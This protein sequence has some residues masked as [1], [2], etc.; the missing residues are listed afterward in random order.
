MAYATTPTLLSLD[1]W[2]AI[3][4][5]SPL[6][7]NG[8]V[9]HDIFP[10]GAGRCA[11]VWFQYSWQWADQVGREDLARAIASAEEDIA[12]V[13]GWWPAPRWFE[14]EPH[15][16]PQFYRPDLYAVNMWNVRGQRKAIKLKWGKLIQGGRRISELQGALVAPAFGNDDGDGFDETVTITQVGIDEDATLCEIKVYFAGHNGDPAY[17]IRPARTADLTGGT[18]TATFWA[19]QF[20]DPDLWNQLPVDG[21]NAIDADDPASYVASVEVR[22]TYNSYIESHGTIFWENDPSYVLQCAVCNGLGCEACSFTTQ[23]LCI[24]AR[25]TDAGFVAITPAAFDVGTESWG[26]TTPA[27]NRDP[28]QVTVNYYAGGQSDRFLAGWDC[29]P[30]ERYLA[31]AIAYLAAARLERPYCSCGIMT[32]LGRDLRR[33]LTVTSTEGTGY[34]TG[35]EVHDNPFGSRLGELMAWRRIKHLADDAINTGG[36]IG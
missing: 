29:D 14:L 15:R 32:A 24:H 22:W 10:A 21:M 31:E 18:F 6:G 30:L 20:I 4:G 7:F 11:D 1:R 26:V 25:D 13:L 19:W 3:M 36:A 12:N 5:V 35:D 33:D 17:E 23:D 8:A 9:S 34:Y 2:A 27:A 16:Y 28:D